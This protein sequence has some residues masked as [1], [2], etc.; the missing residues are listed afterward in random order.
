M[1]EERRSSL[2]KMLD[3]VLNVLKGADST[4]EDKNGLSP[5]KDITGE[6][7]EL[8]DL[9]DRN[10]RLS[11]AKTEVKAKDAIVTLSFTEGTIKE[12]ADLIKSDKCQNIIIMAGAGISTAAGIPDFRSPGTGLYS[13]LQ[14]YNLPYPE[15]IFDIEYFM[16]DPEPFFTL[17]K[18]LYPGQFLPTL[19]HHFIR[20]LQ[21]KKKLL[22]CY[23]Q[24]ID[25]LERVAGVNDDLLVEAH[26]SFHTAHCV[27]LTCH[28]EFS[29]EDVR[30][31][32]LKGNIP[33][34]SR[35]GGLV[36]PDIVFFGEGLPA[37]FFEYLEKDFPQC[38]LLIVMGTSLAVH[39]FASLITKVRKNVPRVLVNMEVAGTEVYGGFDFSNKKRDVF[40]EGKCDEI[41][42]ELIDH[43]SWAEDLESLIKK[44]GE[45]AV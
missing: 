31:T 29:H 5:S 22:R 38:D 17:A 27:D 3:G 16:E 2:L 25:T 20:L 28:D 12:L 39:P 15:A 44:N 34:C 37:R 33:K 35:C 18:E 43:L 6:Q 30:E 4:V 11:E 24:N 26:G 36:K 40:L 19:S 32:I 9:F 10:L 42:K 8:I 23:T 41:L 1:A 21:D 7:E 13:N 14:K 45:D